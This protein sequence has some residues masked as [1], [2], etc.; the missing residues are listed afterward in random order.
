V[1]WN[2]RYGTDT[3]HEGVQKVKAV[4]KR[5]AAGSERARLNGC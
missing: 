4:E 1:K 3:P 5:R 2:R